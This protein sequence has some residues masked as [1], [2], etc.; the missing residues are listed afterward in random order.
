MIVNPF[1]YGADIPIGEFF[2]DRKKEKMELANAMKKGQRV[3][4]FSLRRYGKTSLIHNVLLHLK[5]QGFIVAYIDLSTITDKTQLINH[6]KTL[7]LKIVSKQWFLSWAQKFLAQVKIQ[8]S[9]FTLDF[10]GMNDGEINKLVE[11]TLDLPN[12]LSSKKKKKVIIAFDEFQEINQLNGKNLENLLRSKIQFHNNVSYIFSGSKHHILLNMFDTP[13][14]PFYKAA[15]IM[16]LKKI[17][18]KDYSEFIKD[19]FIETGIDINEKII[20]KILVETENHPYYVQQLCHEI[21]DICKLN[22][23][24][25]VID[26]HI[27]M[28]CNTVLSDQEAVFQLTW[29][30]L[31]PGFK[32]F[33]IG[34]LTINDSIWSKNFK[35]KTNLTEGGIQHAVKS[36]SENYIIEKN[37]ERII[38]SDIFF[39]EWIKKNTLV[40]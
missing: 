37:K 39:K 40:T 3:M 14:R 38:F 15:K 13:D 1:K 30:L 29:E 26:G 27:K 22:M 35:D 23:T 31:S 6:Y 17:P 10:S 5:R 33:L 8:Y 16:E 28:A 2:A 4:L 25:E 21:W 32:R 36:L 7:F 34:I 11:N 9:D 12:Q 20:K 19:K 18:E 24:K